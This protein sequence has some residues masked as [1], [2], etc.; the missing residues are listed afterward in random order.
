M[1][2]ISLFTC[3][4][5]L[6]VFAPVWLLAVCA[7]LYALRFT[8]YELLVLA[9]CIDAYYG[10]FVAIPYYTLVA[11]LTLL[12]VEYIKPRLIVYNERK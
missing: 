9:A 12:I 6:T 2:R 3:M 10:G 11:A 4:A 8:A 1:L 7:F 5:V